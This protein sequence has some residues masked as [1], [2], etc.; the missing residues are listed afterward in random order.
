MPIPAWPSHLDALTAAP[1]F[2]RL[3]LENESVRIL[4]TRIE[5]G[6]TVPLHTHRWPAA[7]YILSYSDL[8]RRDEHGGV[9]LDTRK[10]PLN[11]RPGQ[12]SWLPPLGPHT[13][14][15]VGTTPIHV[16]SIELKHARPA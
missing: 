5:P 14:E 16:I 15:N 1:E 6:Q 11:I 10:T 8:V 7:N 9:T 2:H 12:A 4:D 3:L 13:L